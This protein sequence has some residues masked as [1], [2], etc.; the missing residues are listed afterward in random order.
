MGI[1]CSNIE[2][3]NLH[4]TRFELLHESKLNGPSREHASFPDKGNKASHCMC[5]LSGR[6]WTL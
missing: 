5:V 3:G 4:F 6:I 2:D 1:S